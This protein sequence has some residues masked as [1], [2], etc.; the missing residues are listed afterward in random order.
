MYFFRWG[1]PASD[2]LQCLPPLW[3][4]GRHE[5]TDM[6]W[7]QKTCQGYPALVI[8][9]DWCCSVCLVSLVSFEGAAWNRQINLS[10]QVLLDILLIWE[11]K[12][13][14]YI[15]TWKLTKNFSYWLEVEAWDLQ[16]VKNHRQFGSPGAGRS[17][18]SDVVQAVGDPGSAKALADVMWWYISRV[19][20]VSMASLHIFVHLFNRDEI[21]AKPML[22]PACWNCLRDL[23]G[24]LYNTFGFTM[25]DNA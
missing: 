20:R 21:T 4:F 15:Y 7:L 16:D 12:E 1:C 25:N 2:L 5:A 10:F 8:L 19:L 9:W 18:G 3:F 24:V 13:S 22:G 14:I 17:V 11:G 6:L 23:H